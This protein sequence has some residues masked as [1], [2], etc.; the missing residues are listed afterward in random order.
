MEPVNVS[1]VVPCY[2]VANTLPRCLDSLI[3]Q[4]A[5]AYEIICVNDGSQDTTMDIILDAASKYPNLIRYVDKQNAGLWNA[6]WSGTDVAKGEYV[7][8]V[9]SDDYVDPYFVE[10]FYSTAKEHD[11]DIVVCG[12]KRID[13]DTQAL[14]SIEM[15]E[16]R[17]SFLPQKDPGNLISINSSAWNKCFRRSLLSSMHR[18]EQPPSILEDVALSQLAYLAACEKIAFTGKAPYCYMI[19]ADSMINTITSDQIESVRKALLE[20]RNFFEQEPQGRLLIESFDTTV[21]LHMGIAIP[22]RVSASKQL[23]LTRELTLITHYL[24]EHFPYWRTSRFMTFAYAIK[25][26]GAYLKLYIASCFYKLHLMGPF[27]A[28]YRFVVERLHI[29]I[30]W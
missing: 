24:D 7:A 6:R 19:H 27:L 26:R 1:V 25:H 21:F 18:L 2:N 10:S 3:A 15:S 12:F 29:E 16:E 30:K 8:Y 17:S 4:T 23:D 13:E 22:F 5:K 11:A 9:D 28:V 20:I 14:L